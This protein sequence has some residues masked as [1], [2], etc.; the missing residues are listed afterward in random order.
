MYKIYLFWLGFPWSGSDLSHF[1]FL[2]KKITILELASQKCCDFISRPSICNQ[3]VSFHF[4]SRRK[5]HNFKNSLTFAL[6]D[7]ALKVSWWPFR[8]KLSRYRDFGFHFISKKFMKPLS[9]S[10]NWWLW[11]KVFHTR[12]WQIMPADFYWGTKTSGTDQN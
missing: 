5:L 4:R 2:D 8:C 11:A 6:F 3:L 9:G 12:G 10:G 1:A 7:C